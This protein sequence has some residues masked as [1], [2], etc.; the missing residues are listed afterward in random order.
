LMTGFAAQDMP[1][2]NAACVSV[3]LHGLAGDI[4]SEEKT[5]MTMT[6]TDLVGALS[7][8]HSHSMVLG[9]LELM[10]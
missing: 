7:A 5:R 10:S 4:A 1:P 3:Y 2:Y 6:P 9:G 8:A